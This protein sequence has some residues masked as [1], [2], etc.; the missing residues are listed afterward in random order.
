VK[1]LEAIKVSKTKWL[2][3]IRLMIASGVNS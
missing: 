3:P 2:V 1:E